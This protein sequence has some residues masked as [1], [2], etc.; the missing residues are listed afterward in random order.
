MEK[1][2]VVIFLTYGSGQFEEEVMNHNFMNAGYP[3]YPLEINRK[4]I[5]N[6]INTGYEVAF[7][8]LGADYAITMAN[9]ILEPEGWLKK[10]IEQIEGKTQYISIPTGKARTHHTNEVVIGNT[11]ITKQIFS[12]I[13]YH[14]T[15]YDKKGYGPIDIEYHARV[16]K[17]GFKSAYVLNETAKHLDNGDKAYGFS[18]K[19]IVRSL[20]G[21]Y[22]SRLGLI[23]SGEYNVNIPDIPV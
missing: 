16:I 4:G 11:L 21:D 9:D 7:N 23:K 12:S 10:R 1:R 6:A 5:A 19:E 13:G 8:K 22:V 3:F 20:R 18:K 14:D 2:A 17:A 15:Y